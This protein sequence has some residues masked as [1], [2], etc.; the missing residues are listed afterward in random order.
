MAILNFPA[1]PSVGNT[2]EENGIIYTWD[3]TKW[4]ANSTSAFLPITGGELTGDLT[5]PSLNG[6]PLAGFRNQIINGKM[7]LHQR[8]PS[9]TLITSA[10]SGYHSVDRF[11]FNSN[12]TTGRVNDSSLKNHGFYSVL[13]A[14]R[15]GGNVNVTQMIELPRN[16]DSSQSREGPFTPN[17]QWTLSFWANT[18][19]ASATISFA[20]SSTGSEV[21][22]LI[23]ESVPGAS[24]EV[25]DGP[26]NGFTHYKHTY[27][28]PATLPDRDNTNGLKLLISFPSSGTEIRTTGWQLEP[29]PV[30]TPFENRPIGTELA[31][32]Q[33]YFQVINF[34]SIIFNGNSSSSNVI[35][36]TSAFTEQR[37]TTST[38][39]ALNGSGNILSSG[40]RREGSNASNTTHAIV[41]AGIAQGRAV[42]QIA[43]LAST[44]SFNARTVGGDGTN[45]TFTFDAEL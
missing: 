36:Q 15:A 20:K 4:T 43:R 33:R 14:S 39:K 17:S 1:S 45:T 35:I 12:T 37:L 13:S 9:S 18:L 26:V 25:I 32:C 2:Y 27:T 16:V 5:V 23:V 10:S 6:G 31:L 30:A 7:E 8:Q 28:I 22:D 38:V 42:I 3:G 41:S 44:N 40:G 11:A 29:G 19:P 24:L 34:N 21:T